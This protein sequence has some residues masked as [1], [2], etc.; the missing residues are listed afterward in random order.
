MRTLFSSRPNSPE[1]LFTKYPLETGAS[2]TNRA[3]NA[4]CLCQ[5]R[6]GRLAIATCATSR[7]EIPARSRQYR[8]A[9]RGIPSIARERVSLLS[10]IAAT[11]P[12]SPSSAAAESCPIADNPRM[13]MLEAFAQKMRAIVGNAQKGCT[14]KKNSQKKNTEKQPPQK[15]HGSNKRRH[16]TLRAQPTRRTQRS[17]LRQQTAQPHQNQS[18]LAQ[19]NA[20]QN[21]P[22]FIARIFAQ[23]LLRRIIQQIHQPAVIILLKFMQ[24]ATQPKVQIEFTPQFP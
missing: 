6:Q 16:T 10:S 18:R 19:T 21:L 22:R 7:Q 4:A 14:G 24:R 9:S 23:R 5:A 13:C 12:E 2:G 17:P 11:I 1:A 3:R 8:I 15:N 20:P